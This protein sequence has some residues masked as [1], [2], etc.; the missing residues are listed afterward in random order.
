MVSITGF[1]FRVDSRNAQ[2]QNAY[3]T[4]SHRYSQAY[5]Q[6]TNWTIRFDFDIATAL[7]RLKAQLSAIEHPRP[8]QPDEPH[9]PGTDPLHGGSDGDLDEISDDD[10]DQIQ[11]EIASLKTA[12]ATHDFHLRIEP[13]LRFSRAPFGVEAEILGDAQ[14]TALNGFHPVVNVGKVGR[15]K[16]TSIV[17]K[18]SSVEPAI[19]FSQYFTL[20]DVLI[21]ALGDSYISGEGNPDVPLVPTGA[22]KLYSDMGGVAT[23]QA[24]GS[25]LD[26]K[27][28]P[29]TE[30]ATWQEPLAHRSYKSSPFYAANAVEGRY[31]DAFVTCTTLSYARSGARIDL[32]LIAPFI[33]PDFISP[34][35]KNMRV[36]LNTGASASANVFQIIPIQTDQASTLDY[37]LK[38]G[39]IDEM[40]SAIGNRR[41]DFLIVTI[42]GNDCEWISGFSA[43]IK[44]FFSD[45]DKTVAEVFTEV[46]HIII[47]DLA[48]KFALLNAKI[49][50]LVFP[51]RYV[52]L[53]QYPGSFFG[54][55]TPS[56]PTINRNCGIFDA[57]DLNPF[58]GSDSLIGLDDDEV[59]ILNGL[60]EILNDKLKQIVKDLTLE[61]AAMNAQTPNKGH[62]FSW[63]LVDGI[64]TDFACN[65]YCATDPFYRGAGESFLNQG[66]WRGLLHPNERGQRVY[67][68]R[69]AKKISELIHANLDS[70]RPPS[71]GLKLN[72][73]FG[74][75]DVVLTARPEV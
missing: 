69:I 53:T 60:A 52:L 8:I 32:G 6:P 55:G 12:L 38:L 31:D 48:N 71:E 47:H 18:K 62:Q 44:P 64:D 61:N 72:G 23:L 56:N 4:A 29:E 68:K 24:L 70:L 46:S 21:C 33:A 16:L 28:T 54:S 59:R 58:S 26:D 9:R 35:R 66:D 65:G 45:G 13:V 27:Y 36:A 50:A 75:G 39:Q 43:I 20:I 5:I 67:G 37:Q 51:P 49:A 14:L 10:I 25:Y 74:I 41:P 19:E 57:I 7:T 30:L 73:D 17:K 3:D 2:Q 1:H 22:I 34:T 63:V 11:R 15:Y 42:G 40:R